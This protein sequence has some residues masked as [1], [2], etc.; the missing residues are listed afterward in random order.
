[1]LTSCAAIWIPGFLGVPIFMV[2]KLSNQ[3]GTLRR[4]RQGSRKLLGEVVSCQK[5]LDDDI[6]VV[7]LQYRFTSPQSGQMLNDTQVCKRNDLTNARMPAPGTPV[8]VF[9]RDDL[10]FRV[11]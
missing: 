11:L 2:S 3:K 7:T 1:M 4:L 5:D 9:Y 8:T 6:C 10:T